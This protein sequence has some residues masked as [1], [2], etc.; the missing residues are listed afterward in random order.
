M[1]SCPVPIA[2]DRE[3]YEFL[4]ETAAAG[5]ARKLEQFLHLD[6]PVGI[7]NYIRIAN[8]IAAAVPRGR[9]LDWGCGLG[10]MT[11][12]LRRR[13][14]EVTAFDVGTLDAALPDLPLTRGL[15]VVRTTHPTR[16]PFEDASFDVVLSC[17]V[18]EH[19]DEFSQP[20]NELL[21]LKEIHR[22]LRPHGWFSIYQLPQQHAWQE[23]ISR[24]RGVG[25][26]HP[27][28]FTAREIRALLERTGFRI[29]RLRRNNM[30]P[31]NL[32]GMPESVRTLYSRVARGIVGLDGLLSRAP[33]LN[34]I[35]GVLEVL[36]Q[37]IP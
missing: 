20:G 8:E 3:E 14:F 21:S 22:V 1:L 32:T 7:W 35:A 5:K 19:V 25:Y 36:A 10:Q 24:R 37:Q 30:F 27:R 18:L 34:R 23:A 13:G 2:S 33:G 15:R 12:L 29:R 31:K 16:L 6:Q 4:L 11:W 28:R 9:V 26:S 17:G